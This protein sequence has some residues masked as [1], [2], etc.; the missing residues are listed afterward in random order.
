[1]TRLADLPRGTRRAV[2]LIGATCAFTMVGAAWAAWTVT[3]S[4][5]ATTSIGQ[6]V[7]LTVGVTMPSD[8]YPGASKNISVTV[9]N[10]N[11]FAID[12]TSIT[13]SSVTSNDAVN[14]A[15]TNLS[16]TPA[17]PNTRI[18]PNSTQT[19]L[20]GSAATLSVN[21]TDACQGKTFTATATVNGQTPNGN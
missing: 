17:T 18:G 2:T 8:L 16:L 14:C 21:A 1:M 7:P 19:I 15:G 6:A 10:P 20:L 9:N 3:G 5:P 11:S 13:W 4:A 12:V